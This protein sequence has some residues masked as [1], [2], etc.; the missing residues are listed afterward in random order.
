[1][2]NRGKG[3]QQKSYSWVALQAGVPR[4]Q[5]ER[6]PFMRMAEGLLFVCSVR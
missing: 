5:V 4:I 2:R 3:Q 6:A 1:M